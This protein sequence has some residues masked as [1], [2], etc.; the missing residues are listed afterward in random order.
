[1]FAITMFCRF[2]LLELLPGLIVSDGW[3][4]LLRVWQKYLDRGLKT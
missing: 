3:L 1:M 2:I 4:V